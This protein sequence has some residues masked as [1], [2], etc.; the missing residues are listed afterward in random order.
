M[1][2]GGSSTSTSP[3]KPRSQLRSVLD[4]GI[5]AQGFAR[6]R[7]PDCGHER[8]VAFSCKG[9]CLCPSCMGRR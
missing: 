8:I 1:K 7:C 9:R 4:C 5:P 3:P 6:L 2:S